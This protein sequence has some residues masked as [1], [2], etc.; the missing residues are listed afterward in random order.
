MSD[1]VET[2]LDWICHRGGEHRDVLPLCLRC[3]SVYAGG[4]LGVL[5]EA[6]LR[7]VL[8]VKTA[9]L[10]FVISGPLPL[11]LMGV[12]GF[13]DIYGFLTVSSGVKVL[14]ALWFG[15][16]LVF[17]SAEAVLHRAGRAPEG[18]KSQVLSRCAFVACLALWADLVGKGQA[19]ALMLLAWA[20]GAGL[21]AVFLVVNFA[22]A[23]LVLRRVKRTAWRMAAA[24]PAAVALVTVE[25]ALFRLWRQV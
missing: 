15:S 4:L 16:A 6:L 25:F 5:L 10:V 3:S 1:L 22:I 12:V 20:A 23:F 8:R 19:T 14:T 24:M 11:A 7:V 9:R 2:L 17:L 21:A 13:G 18:G